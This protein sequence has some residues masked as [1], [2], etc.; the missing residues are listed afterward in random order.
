[1]RHHIKAWAAGAA[2]LVMLTAG[3]ALAQAKTTINVQYPLGFIFDKVFVTLKT[4]FEK[5]NPDIA[6]NYLPA[7]KE[8]EDAAQTALRQ[9]ITKQLPDVALQA[10]NLQRLFVDRKIAVDLTPFIAKEK[11]WKGQGFSPAMMALGTYGGKPYGLAF[12]VSTPIVYVND[13]L[14]RKAGGDPASFPTTWD[15]IF[16]LAKK[17]NALGDDNVGLFYSWAITGNWMWQALVFSHGGTMMSADEKAIAF[18][19]EPGKKSIDLLGRMVK[20]VGMPNLTPEASRAAFFAGK[21]AIWTESTSLLRVADDGV[22][23][24]FKWRTARFPVPGPDA[25]LPTGG[26]SA[27]MFATEPAKQAAAWKFMKFITG[28]EGATI[29]VKGT[30]YM[31]PNSLPATN[32]AMLKDFYAEKPNHLTSLSQQP[33]MTAWYAF[34]GDNNLKIIQAIKDR[35]QTVVD[36]SA[37]PD[38]ALSAMAADVQ[39]L[40]PK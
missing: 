9:A 22:A 2:A 28:A 27:L 20:D 4:E 40:L 11:D 21:L 33:L 38:A 36:K 7:Y 34:P 15:G 5:Q 12:A 37:A 25:K 32:P 26:A 23:G 16:D 1:M 18:D 13:D 3:Q 19:K 30:G 8:Y 14:V 35:L 10:I 24:K 39:K 17:V 6:V 31:P 29:M